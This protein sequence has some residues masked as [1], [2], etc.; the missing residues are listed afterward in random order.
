MYTTST[1]LLE[2]HLERRTF[3]LLLA[4]VHLCWQKQRVQYIVPH[5]QHQVHRRDPISIRL[6]RTMMKS[7]FFFKL[8]LRFGIICHDLKDM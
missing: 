7:F 4:K 5:Q 1:G 3:S 8:S 2:L 6:V